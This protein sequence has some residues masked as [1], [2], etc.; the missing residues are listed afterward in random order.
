MKGAHYLYG[1]SLSISVVLAALIHFKG[2]FHRP[3]KFFSYIIL[4]IFTL[5]SYRL[6]IFVYDLGTC[7]DRTLISAE[8]LYITYDKPKKVVFQAEPGAQ[9][10]I[11]HR[12]VTGRNHIGESFSTELSVSKFGALVEDESSLILTMNKQC[13]LYK[14]NKH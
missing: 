1:S 10:H 12:I 7:M 8:S 11:L 9:E 2:R 3:L 14:L 5:H 6:Q 13:Y 4:I